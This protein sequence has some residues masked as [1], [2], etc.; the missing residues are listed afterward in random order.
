MKHSKVI[1]SFYSA[2]KSDLVEK[3]ENFLLWWK[4]VE[5]KINGVLKEE[6]NV[7]ELNR[8][9]DTKVSKTV[10]I[11]M[12]GIQMQNRNRNK[13]NW[14]E[15]TKK[16]LIFSFVENGNRARATIFTKMVNEPCEIYPRHKQIQ[17]LLINFT[18]SVTIYLDVT[19]MFH[20]I[21]KGKSHWDLKRTYYFFLL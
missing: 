20:V 1:S 21:I 19:S 16:T 7:I 3:K 9:K 12:W 13:L 6:E 10:E 8:K 18:R 4:R 17:N 11:F 15:T 5:S 2:H 14:N